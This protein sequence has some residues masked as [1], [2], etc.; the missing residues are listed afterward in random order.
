MAIDQAQAHRMIH[1]G[2][3]TLCGRTCSDTWMKYQ[4]AEGDSLGICSHTI[5]IEN[6]MLKG[7]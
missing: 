5:V 6:W 1:S 7:L 3:V 4:V 2:V